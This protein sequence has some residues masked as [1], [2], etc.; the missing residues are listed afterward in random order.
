MEKNEPIIVQQTFP[1]AKEEVWKAITETDLMKKWFFETMESFKP[2]VGFEMR[3]N[4]HV[5]G[6]DFVHKWKITEVEHE[7]KIVYNWRYEGYEGDSFVKW[8]LLAENNQT[9]L[10]LT[11]EGIETF[12]QHIAEFSRES[13]EGGWNY[14]IEKQLRAFL[15]N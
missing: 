15:E 8:E 1:V 4:V 3:F 2:E 13:C 14:F 7:K 6:K 9:K 12:P 10:T 11:H 5:E